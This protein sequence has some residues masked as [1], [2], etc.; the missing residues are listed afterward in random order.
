MRRGDV[1]LLGLSGALLLAV[2]IPVVAQSGPQSLLPPGFGE[3]D[4]SPSANQPS[5]PRPAQPGSSSP[6]PSSSSSSAASSASPA[7]NLVPPTALALPSEQDLGNAAAPQEK[8]NPE[9]Y[10]LPASARRSLAQVGPLTPE[11]GGVSPDSYGRVRGQFLS[12]LMRASHAP[13]VSRWAS[14]TLRRVLLSGTTTPSD[15]DGADLV[16]ERASLLLR[17]G[18]ADAARLLVQSVDSDN[19]TPRLYA[20]A[21]DSYLATADPA[22]FCPLAPE[23]AV[24]TQDPR[25]QMALAICASFS[26]DQGTATSLLNQQQRQG[27]L[28]GIDYRLAEKTVGAG[29][30]SRRSVKIEWD[31]VDGLNAWRFGLATATN[32]TI[33]D[34]LY[35]SGG[36]AIRAWEARAPALP[37]NRR[38]AGV[39]TASRLGVF[40]SGALAAFYSQLGDPSDEDQSKTGSLFEAFRRAYAGETLG[41][42]ITGMRSFWTADSADGAAK[43]PGGVSYAA[44][45]ALARAA[46]ALPPNADAGADM[47]WILGAMLSGGFDRN[48]ANWVRAANALE[49]DGKQRAWAL[50]AVGLPDTSVGIARDRIDA[51][52]AAD[53]SDKKI[54]SH[55]LVASLVGLGRLDAGQAA[56]V[57]SGLEMQLTIRS[58]WSRVLAQAAAERQ[59]GTVALLAAVGMQAPGWAQLPPEHLAAILTAMRQVGLEPEARMIAAEAMT[60]L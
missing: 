10:D 36:D 7:T 56:S 50:L 59:K 45:P 15:I 42:R 53:T 40:S 34:A 49:G 48:A 5:Q 57:M 31:G 8:K 1:A 27:K 44:L 32:V 16:A 52:V 60:R 13:F 14:I 58:R 35:A 19:F 2:A 37:L 6:A 24:R 25:W 41:D 22:G 12:G 39:A 30:N 43:G 18:E 33:P 46:A 20:V 9:E 26:S 28:R 11:T 17:M 55:M 51:F 4:S 3:P 29:P 54:A 21:M 38:L 47:P 23:A